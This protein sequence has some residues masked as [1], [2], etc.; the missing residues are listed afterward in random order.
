M[1][2]TL[3]L[4][5][6]CLGSQQSV[7][8]HFMIRTTL[9]YLHCVIIWK[10]SQNWLAKI[11][12]LITKPNGNRCDTTAFRG[13]DFVYLLQIGVVVIRHGSYSFEC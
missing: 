6:K 3:K 4:D 7:C 1:I 5:K 12:G 8:V 13:F 2:R 9:L 11:C 10:F